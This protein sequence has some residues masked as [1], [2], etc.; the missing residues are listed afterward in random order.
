[1]AKNRLIDLNDHLFMQLER[2][3]DDNLIGADLDRELKRSKGM[4]DVADKVIR[5]ADLLLRARIAADSTISGDKILP[6][7]LG[8]DYGPDADTQIGIENSKEVFKQ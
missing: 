4:T 1:M 6:K 7:I 3:N 2:L 8:A 5:N